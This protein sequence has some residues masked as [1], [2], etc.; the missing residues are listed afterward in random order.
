MGRKD[1]KSICCPL[2]TKTVS[3]AAAMNPAPMIL[4][5]YRMAIAFALQ[6]ARE[7]GPNNL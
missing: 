4:R 1:R 6:K 7:I 3:K 5:L 2:A